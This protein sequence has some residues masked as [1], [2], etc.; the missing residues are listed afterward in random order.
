M[1]ISNSVPIAVN[2]V[3]KLAIGFQGEAVE[4][5][6]VEGSVFGVQFGLFLGMVFNLGTMKWF[7]V[8]VSCVGVLDGK[9]DFGEALFL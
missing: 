8:Y 6:F 1:M 9:E 7:G 3:V 4:S 2:G 5:V